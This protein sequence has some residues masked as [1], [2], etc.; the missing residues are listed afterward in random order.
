MTEHMPTPPDGLDVNQLKAWEREVRE[1]W[2]LAQRARE[3]SRAN[4]QRETASDRRRN[5]RAQSFS[6]QVTS[7]SR[8]ELI[9][10]LEEVEPGR[11]AE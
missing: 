5:E 11:A 8:A 9:D 6:E 4:N 2:M 10:S 1:P 3:D 7:M